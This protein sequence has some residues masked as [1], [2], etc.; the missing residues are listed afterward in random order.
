MV[1][2]D[3]D[4]LNELYEATG[5]ASWA[6][7]INWGTNA[8]LSE[9]HGITVNE[10][11]RVVKLVLDSNCLEGTIEIMLRACPN[12][13]PCCA[14]KMGQRVIVGSSVHPYARVC[15]V[16]GGRYPLYN[17]KLLTL[18]VSRLLRSDF[19]KGSDASMDQSI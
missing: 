10:K 15:V 2:T 18:V 3:R 14:G 5:G 1:S 8:P 17:R 9:W 11:G 19:L 4:A 13:H 7:N 12:N 6:T 16:S